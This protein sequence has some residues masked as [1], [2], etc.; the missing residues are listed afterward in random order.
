MIEILWLGR[1]GQGAFTAAKL[2]GA[3]YAA[4][5][6]T[7]N[8]LAFPSFGPE[9]RGAPVRAFTKL[10]TKPILDR[11][12]TEKAD[13]IVVLDETLYN[14]N[15]MN[16][17]K[18]N[19]KIIVNTKS[20]D[21]ND[22]IS[23]DGSRFAKELKLPVVNTVMLGALSALSGIVEEQDL[24]TAIEG[25]MPQKIHEKNKQAVLSAVREVVG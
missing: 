16:M 4:K 23:F 21:E 19:G 14:E 1:G 5:G 22:L 8:A 24:F 18:N 12:E 20:S 10:D 6:D 13:Y 15:L 2:L 3:A 9:R 25:Y 7:Y 17:L 11:S